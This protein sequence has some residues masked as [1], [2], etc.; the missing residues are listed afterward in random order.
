MTKEQLAKAIAHAISNVESRIMGIGAEQYD[1]GKKQKI[2]DKTPSEVLDDAIEELDDL[3]AYVAWTRI[4]VQ[5][6]RA[7]LSDFS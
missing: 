5:K 1:Q 3:L 2:E 6:L 7:N 4:R